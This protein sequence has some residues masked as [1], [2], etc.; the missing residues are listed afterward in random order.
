MAFVKVVK[1]K[2]YFKRFQTQFKRRR[3][4]KTDYLARKKMI[5]QDVNKYLA[6][7]YRL[8]ARVTNTKIIT[9]VV[10]S[11]LQGDKVVS[12]ATSQELKKF[13]LTTGLSNY[14]AAYATGLLLARRTLAT[15]NLDK[16]FAAN[17]KIDGNDFDISAVNV[18]SRRPFMCILDIGL[19]RSTVGNR[20]FGV[21]KGATDGGLHVPHSV[22]K[23]PGFSKD[24]D[25]KK[26]TFSAEVHRDRI[27]GVHIDEYMKKLKAESQEAYQ[28]QFSQW[29]KCLTENKAKSVEEIMQKIFDKI[30]ADPAYVK[31]GKKIYKPKFLNEQK[32]LVQ[33]GSKQYKR[34]VRLTKEERDARIEKKIATAKEQ[35]KQLE[36]N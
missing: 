4:G 17:K 36:K 14:S 30:K 6:P 16:S 28:K 20:V 3:E 10:Y 27:F 23:F 21:L 19:I 29:D 12:Q 8:V 35:I 5:S 15:L 32:T 24:K 1:N 18:G 26:T 34:E 22:K 11:T 13:G 31:K 33:S 7:K 25:S 2:A 9:Q